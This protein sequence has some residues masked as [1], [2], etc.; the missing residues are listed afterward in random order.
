MRDLPTEELVSRLHF[1]E[2][3]EVIVSSTPPNFFDKYF[4]LEAYLES[5]TK[6]PTAPQ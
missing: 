1:A 5:C 2:G 3:K 4:I 6:P